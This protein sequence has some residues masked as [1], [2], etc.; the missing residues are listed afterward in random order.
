MGGAYD[1]QPHA[2]PCGGFTTRKR[3]NPRE[4]LTTRNPRETRRWTHD[5]EPVR[6]LAENSRLKTRANPDWGLAARNPR[7]TRQWTHD[8]DPVQTLAGDSRREIRENPEERLARH[9]QNYY[10]RFISAAVFSK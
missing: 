4:R 3:A 9:A 1:S 5:T 8:T 6:I 10:C 7:E 2:K